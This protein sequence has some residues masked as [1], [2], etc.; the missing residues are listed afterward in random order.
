MVSPLQ[1][2]SRPTILIIE[3]E[4]LFADLLTRELST[5]NAQTFSAL[6]LDDARD[7]L[8]KSLPDV[9]VVDLRLSNLSGFV[10]DA[11]AAS[12]QTTLIGLASD[13]D[14]NCFRRL[15]ARASAKA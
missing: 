3:G 10:K 1:H 8:K 9:C 6:S 5:T 11:Q 4:K 14:Q 7:L 15:R 2:K 13:S 12:P